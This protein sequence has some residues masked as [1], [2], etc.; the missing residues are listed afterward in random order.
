MGIQSDREGAFSTSVAYSSEIGKREAS[1]LT[2][3]V[4]H[5]L[6]LYV[7][8]GKKASNLTERVPSP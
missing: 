2:D 8:D 5:L 7:A 3:S 6:D 4:P 1:N